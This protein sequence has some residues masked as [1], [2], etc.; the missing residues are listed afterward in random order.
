VN[1]R[2]P[3]K[4]W[5]A[6]ENEVWKILFERQF[7]NV[8]KYACQRYFEGHKLLGL[9]PDHLPDFNELNER[10]QEL[11][12]WELVST[13]VQYSSG[14]D[15]FEHL[16]K[17]EFLVTEYI[18]ERD[19]LDYTPLPDIWHDTFGHLPMLA[20]KDYADLVYDYA[21]VMVRLSKE[22]RKGLGSIWWYTI[23][24]GMIRENN[25]LKA[26]G[27]GLFSSHDEIQIA[28]TDKMRKLPFDPET[29]APV[30]PSPH[31]I[32]DTLWTLDS[33]D[34][35]KGFVQDQLQNVEKV[36]P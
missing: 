27:A 24:F 29:I 35:L 17:R 3:F 30:A 25:D 12:G 4:K 11:V 14:Q 19:S 26:F 36:A 20:H 32:H 23:E 18:R 5:S 6:A 15:W 16:V 8:Q 7:P 33:F 1:V 2:R 31:H 13:D 28:F 21:Q 9:T 10:F 34:Q 22:E